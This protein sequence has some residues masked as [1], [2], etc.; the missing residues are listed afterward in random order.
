MLKDQKQGIESL[1]DWVDIQ[2]SFFSLKRQLKN[3]EL[4]S[5]LL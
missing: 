1:G 2:Y 4:I 5:L 3:S